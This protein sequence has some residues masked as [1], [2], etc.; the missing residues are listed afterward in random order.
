M[1]VCVC[2]YPN[3][4]CLHVVSSREMNAPHTH[5]INHFLYQCQAAD[6]SL[7]LCLALTLYF[8]PQLFF[9]PFFPLSPPFYLLPPLSLSRSPHLTTNTHMHSNPTNCTLF[10]SPLLFTQFAF[11]PLSIRPSHIGS[12]CISRAKTA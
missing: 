8:S 2:K 3:T 4:E 6:F 11:S 10:P 9:M 12:G 5:F 7:S 1:C